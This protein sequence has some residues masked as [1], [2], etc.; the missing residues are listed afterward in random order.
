MFH[1]HAPRSGAANQA[2]Q[3]NRTHHRLFHVFLKN[4]DIRP[5]RHIHPAIENGNALIFVH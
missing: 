5:L 2:G 4:V 1:T 3:T